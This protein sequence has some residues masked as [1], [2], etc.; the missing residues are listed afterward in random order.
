MNGADS[1]LEAALGRVLTAGSI[2]STVMLALGLLLDLIAPRA[3]VS[4]WALH[5]GLIVL[6]GTP[7]TRVFVSV[8][9]YARQ[10]DW[11]FVTLTLI[12]LVLLG[13][14]VVAAFSA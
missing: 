5:A 12:V 13:A 8:V 7:V 11:L 6:M 14:S 10:G 4:Q 9:E 2:A 3:R 1:G